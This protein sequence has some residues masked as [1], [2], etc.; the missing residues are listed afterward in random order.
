[1][2][3]C[4]GV[5]T[6]LSSFFAVADMLSADSNPPALNRFTPD[7]SDGRTSMYASDSRSCCR[8]NV[9]LGRDA[10]APDAI[11]RVYPSL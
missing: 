1:V 3:V 10:G 2:Y 4:G 11:I 7:G 6:A 9:V 5:V 8:W